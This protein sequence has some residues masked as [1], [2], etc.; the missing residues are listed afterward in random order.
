MDEFTRIVPTSVTEDTIKD[1][2]TDGKTMLDIKS[3]SLDDKVAIIKIA[4]NCED[5]TDPLMIMNLINLVKV[6][7]T[8]ADDYFESPDVYVNSVEELLDLKLALSANLKEFARNIVIY[9]L[10][11]LKSYHKTSYNSTDSHKPLPPLYNMFFW[12]VDF[13]TLSGILAK[14][15]E[16]STKELTFID[17]APNILMALI[18]KSA[19]S[20]VLMEQFFKDKEVGE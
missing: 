4:L 6:Y 13:L 5:V 7:N 3:L 1:Y 10:S 14:A 8:L 12:S 15:P 2:L 18:T 19:N 9:F 17:G 11:I 16:V 20:L